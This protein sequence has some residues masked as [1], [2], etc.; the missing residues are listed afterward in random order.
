MQSC[1]NDYIVFDNRDGKITCPESIAVN[2]VIPHYGIGGDGIVL[3]E[4]SSVADAKMRVF[5]KDGLEIS[6]AGNLI[7]MVGK[8]KKGTLLG[9]PVADKYIVYK[10]C[11][12]ITVEA[13]A[14]SDVCI[15]GEVEPFGRIQIE[16][17]QQAFYFSIPQ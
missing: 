13:T 3:I 10:Q 5:N 11:R 8:Y 1:G 4:K 14:Q 6:I 16:A 9:T 7:R 15:D 12:S 17:A 2:Y